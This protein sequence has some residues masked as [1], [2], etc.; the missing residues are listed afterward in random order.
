MAQTKII[1]FCGRSQSGK[2]LSCNYIMGMAYKSNGLIDSF[3]IANN[4]NLVIEGESPFFTCNELS[5]IPKETGHTP[6]TGG[7]ITLHP[8]NVVR[9]LSFADPIKECAITMFGI[10]PEIV[11]GDNEDKE[12][13]TKY[14][15]SDFQKLLG[16][17]YPWRGH[18]GDELLSVRN[19]LQIIGTDI[20]RMIN[21]N[22]WI[23]R[24]LEK[25]ERTKEEGCQLI[26]VDDVR[27][28]NEIE[29]LKNIGATIIG[30][31]RYNSQSNHQSEFPSLGL[32]DYV[33]D[34]INMTIEEYCIKLFDIVKTII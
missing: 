19:L 13:L 12:T 11:F 27:F 8:Y 16:E 33:I 20:G 18:K 34:N 10:K 29:A 6:K 5:N 28:D 15:A 22:I 3:S 31:T 30:L 17:S 9:T 1:G 4:G 21:K 14:T 23:D 2:G 24:L 32:C 7:I 25:I 26:L